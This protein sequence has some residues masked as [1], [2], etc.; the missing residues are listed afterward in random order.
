MSQDIGKH[1]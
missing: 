1:V